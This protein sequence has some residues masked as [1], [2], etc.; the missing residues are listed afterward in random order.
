MCKACNSKGHW[1]KFCRKSQRKQHK[2]KSPNR[3]GSSRPRAK[4]HKRTDRC[5]SRESPR[6]MDRIRSS[7][8]QQDNTATEQYSNEQPQE[9]LF[10]S[11]TISDLC[12]AHIQQCKPDEAFTTLDVICPDLIGQKKL[13]LK[14]YTGASTNTL[15]LSTIVQMSDNRWKSCVQPARA[16]LTAYNG[17]EIRCLGFLHIMCR[18]KGSTPSKEKFYVADVPGPAI[19]GLP[20]CRRLKVVTIHSVS[21]P[22]NTAEQTAH[23]PTLP[24]SLRLDRPSS[25]FETLLTKSYWGHQSTPWM[26]W[27]DGFPGSL[28]HL[29]TS[30]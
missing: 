30:R 22:S 1:A 25:H 19:A 3:R 9:S 16:M 23:Q 18:Y 21:S 5:K 8:Q 7:Q 26:I 12:M 24:T 11:F 4:P 2:S 29:E 10:C 6:H 20:T 28:T 14:M 17:S 27:S 15:P 13:K